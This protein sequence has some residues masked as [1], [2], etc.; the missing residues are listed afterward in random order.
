MGELLG[1]QGTRRSRQ[2]CHIFEHK[3]DHPLVRKHGAE[4][5]AHAEAECH[6]EAEGLAEAVA[7][8]VD[9]TDTASIVLLRAVI[10]SNGTVGTIA[11]IS[12][13]AVAV[14]AF[15]GSRDILCAHAVTRAHV[16]TTSAVVA[17]LVAY[18]ISV[19]IA[20]VSAVAVAVAAFVGSCDTRCALA[21]ITRVVIHLG[22]HIIAEAAT[23]EHADTTPTV[24]T[25]PHGVAGVGLRFGVGVFGSGRAPGAARK[26][27]RR[28]CRHA[29]TGSSIGGALCAR[30]R[31]KLSGRE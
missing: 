12:A 7:A 18:A 2:A 3:L 1:G 10:V 28:V 13:V 8:C 27:L 15:A 30:E 6:P 21:D 24:V 14:A 5:E 11:A 9:I 22:L 17:A 29:R 20:A 16:D 23:R 26:G 31:R 4:T 25:A 19:A